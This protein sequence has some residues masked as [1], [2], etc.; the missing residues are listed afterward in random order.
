[1]KRST[2]LVSALIG[3]TATNLGFHTLRARRASMWK[4]KLAPGDTMPPLDITPP[5]FGLSS[6]TA[7]AP[8]P[9]GCRLLVFF[10][11]DCPHCHT[12]AAR[13]AVAWDSTWTVPVVWITNVDDEATMQF[14]QA[15]GAHTQVRL[16]GPHATD[17]LNAAGVPAA[18][19]VSAPNVV[20]WTGPYGGGAA[21]QR[22]LERICTEHV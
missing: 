14:A 2:L 17:V 11:T 9:S 4:S 20:L 18:F 15:A 6:A 21:E 1:M 10:A 12:A 3:I 5:H 22:A 13:D 8:L 7:A 16:A 19:L